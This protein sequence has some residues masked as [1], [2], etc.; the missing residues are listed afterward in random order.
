MSDTPTGIMGEGLIFTEGISIEVIKRG[1]VTKDGSWQCKE[2]GD[3]F[4]HATDLSKHLKSVDAG[5]VCSNCHKPIDDDL[6]TW[7][8]ESRG[9]FWGTPCSERVP[10]GYTCPHCG[11]KEDL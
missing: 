2:C 10:T 11:H 4:P 7:T 5:E 6:V 3:T 9:E 1:R 8:T